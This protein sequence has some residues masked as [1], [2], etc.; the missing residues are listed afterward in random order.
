MTKLL[1]IDL[2][3]F[4]KE[5][6]TVELTSNGLTFL[7]VT[8]RSDYRRYSDRFIIPHKYDTSS[9]EAKLDLGILTIY[10]NL[11]ESAVPR[12]ITVV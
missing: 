2:P 4:T 10:A 3:G 6:V 8:A 9:M 5:Q 7:N 11:K 12:R 1:E